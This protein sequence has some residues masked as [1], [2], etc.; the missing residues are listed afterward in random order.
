MKSLLEKKILLSN[1]TC[2]SLFLFNENK[3]IKFF[4]ERNSFYFFSN[5]FSFNLET[6]SLK[7]K[8]LSIRSN[9]TEKF[10]FNSLIFYI[11][12]FQKITRKKVSIKGLGYR[13]IVLETKPDVKNSK[14]FLQF[15]LGFSHFKTIVIPSKVQNYY[16]TKNSITFES[17]NASQLGN[18]VT[19]IK[20]FRKPDIYKGKGLH[21]KNQKVLVLKPLKKK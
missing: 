15:K 18:Y 10:L 6:P 13:I 9:K 11:F 21:I 3:Y 7:K 4:N 16:L 12:Q 20:S 2:L 14:V 17:Y 8:F 5:S 19:K 1:E